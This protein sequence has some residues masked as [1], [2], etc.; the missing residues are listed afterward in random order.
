MAGIYIHIP[1]CKQA[2]HYCNFFF[3]TSLKLK[4]DLISALILEIELQKNFLSGEMVET[5]YFGGGTPS[6]LSEKDLDEIFNQIQKHFTISSDPEI[7]LEANPD[8]LNADNISILKNCPVNR[9]S[10]GIQSFHEADLKYM[11]RA[12]N[13]IEASDC[14]EKVQSAGFENLNIDLIYG[15][16]GLS[17]ELWLENL[18]KFHENKI[19]HLSAYA[20]TVEE[21]TAL[22][23]FIKT[24]KSQALNDEQARSQMILLMDFMRHSGYEHYEVSNFALPGKRSRHNSSYWK[25][26]A[27]LGLGP[28]AHSHQSNFRQW[29]I[30]NNAKYIQSIKTGKVPMEREILSEIQQYN[31]FL[32][33]SLRTVWGID[34]KIIEERFGK[35]KLEDLLLNSIPFQNSGKMIQNQGVLKL[36]PTGML[37]ADRITAELFLD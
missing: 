17:D 28:A 34:L 4:N 31:E 18:N 25:G 20:L 1:F 12:H 11:N 36:N 16:P 7:T 33:V 30:A 23:H 8:D 22:D 27:Y 9:L 15:T 24:G 2:C 10:I 37:E 3:S 14:I 32:M 5:I 29:N 13:A 19:T 26:A 21:S 35:E 6:L